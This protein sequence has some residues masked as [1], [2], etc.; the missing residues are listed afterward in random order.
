MRIISRMIWIKDRVRLLRPGGKTQ[1]GLAAALGLDPS[2]VTEIIK[3]D[4]QIKRSEVAPLAAYLEM[5]V[6]D[7]MA[8]MDGRPPRAPL[9]VA[10]SPMLPVLYPPGRPDVPVW[11]SAQAGDDGAI[12]LTPDPIDYIHRS[13]RMRGVKN[14]FAF[15]VVGTS[16]SPAIEHGTQV[17]I[18][19]SLLPMA[20]RDHVFI[21]DLPDGTMKA[22]VKRLI[23]STER[24]W[25]VRQ[26]NEL[27]DFDL[28]RTVWT[29]AYRITEKRE[30]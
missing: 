16:M 15:Y 13:D 17:V 8:A 3:G 20:G 2:R 23:R 19:P 21:Q 29:K 27:K 22:M 10:A 24:S 30:D 12:V 6:A 7:V 1:T 28:L 11:A 5:T 18:N 26:F 25:R 4:R 14:P 9:G